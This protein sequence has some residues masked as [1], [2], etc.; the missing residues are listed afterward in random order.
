MSTRAASAPL[1]PNARLRW[2]VVARQVEAIAPRTV[3]EIGCGGG[4]FGARIAGRPGVD[5]LGVEPDPTSYEVARGRIEPRGG[6]VRNESSSDLP[7]GSDFD[8]VCAFEVLEHLEDDVA[9]LEEWTTHVRPGGHL[10]LSVPAFQSRFNPW[11]TMVGHFR[12]Y[13]PDGLRSLLEAAGYVDVDVTV[14]GWPLGLATENVRGR[15]AGR[16][17]AGGAVGGSTAEGGSAAPADT[18]AERTASSARQLQ[19]SDVLGPVVTLAVSPFTA[20]QRLRP[21]AGTGLVALGRR[22]G[23]ASG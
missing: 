20:L 21:H 2:S 4:A 12:R 13:E 5:Y 3:L 1:A 6:A 23:P 18:F 14:Y 22:P 19:P 15:I 9:A 10:L 11:D 8:L 7:S 17:L 16:R